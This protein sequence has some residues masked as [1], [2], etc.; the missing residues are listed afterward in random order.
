MQ[1]FTHLSDCSYNIFGKWFLSSLTVSWPTDRP[2]A[3]RCSQLDC[4][5][6]PPHGTQWNIPRSAS[7]SLGS[8]VRITIRR[9]RGA[10]WRPKNRTTDR[11]SCKLARLC[12]HLADDGDCAARPTTSGPPIFLV[13][14]LR[15]E[16]R[17]NRRRHS[18]SNVTSDGSTNRYFLNSSCK[19]LSRSRCLYI[20]GRLNW[21]QNNRPMMDYGINASLHIA[22]PHWPFGP[23]TKGLPWLHAM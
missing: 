20:T 7:E 1:R 19:L 18:E 6:R 2:T 21:G 9:L 17:G 22:S 13:V 10:V 14:C 11:R 12:R 4:G 23:K 16:K 8:S 5:R 3:L 15:G